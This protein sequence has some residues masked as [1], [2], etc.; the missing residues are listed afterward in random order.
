L[1]ALGRRGG[2]VGPKAGLDTEVRGK[3]RNKQLFPILQIHGGD[4]IIVGSA[5]V[6]KN[7][8]LIITKRG[9]YN[10]YTKRCSRM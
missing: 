8:R 7:I 6:F 1:E 2:C 5:W 3:M 9:H 10:T 4:N